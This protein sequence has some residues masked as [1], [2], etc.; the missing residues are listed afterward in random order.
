MNPIP[1][2]DIFEGLR[3]LWQGVDTANRRLENIDESR[4]DR[5]W[6][7]GETDDS[8][9]AEQEK[10]LASDRERI[11][12]QI[13]NLANTR[14]I[15][16]QSLIIALDKIVKGVTPTVANSNVGPLVPPQPLS[17]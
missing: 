3:F 8:L 5:W 10:E 13:I 15:V 7:V 6:W 12:E 17:A 14:S 9:S 16:G 1:L 4:E 2:P 11:Q